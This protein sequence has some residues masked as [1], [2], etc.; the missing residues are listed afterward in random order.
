MGG[1]TI[2]GTGG[3]A[4]I[5]FTALTVLAGTVGTKLVDEMTNRILLVARGTVPVRTGNLRDSHTPSIRQEALRVAG[6]VSAEAE[7]AAAVHDGAKMRNGKKR[8]GNPWLARAA[9]SSVVG[10]GWKFTANKG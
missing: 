6:Q 3:R 7:Y 4:T 8:K 10:Q 9:R 5:S 1:I 2:R